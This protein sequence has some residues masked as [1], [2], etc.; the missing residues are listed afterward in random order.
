[1]T[2]K[3]K[4]TDELRSLLL[5]DEKI[6]AAVGDNIY[7]II[8]PVDT[9]GD[10]IAYAR[11]KY[12]VT[13]NKMGISQQMCNVMVTIIS[14][15]YDRARDICSDVFNCLIGSHNGYMYNLVDSVED[16][17]NDKYAEA[18]LFEIV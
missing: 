1:M 12:T 9:E 5:A 17:V 16:Y 6:N 18:L 3:I 4:I 8:A 15:D 2:N 14:D 11:E 10:F 13:T 7:P